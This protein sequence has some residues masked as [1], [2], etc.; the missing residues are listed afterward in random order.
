MLDGLWMSSFRGHKIRE[1]K[2]HDKRGYTGMVALS[3]VIINASVHVERTC[4]R[5]TLVRHS[6][7]N[8]LIR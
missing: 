1:D 8:D 4:S 7:H 3:I 2:K 6:L 5:T